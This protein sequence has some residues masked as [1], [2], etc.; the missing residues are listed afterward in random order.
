MWRQGGAF[1]HPTKDNRPRKRFMMEAAEAG[2]HQ[3]LEPVYLGGSSLSQ[4][5]WLFCPASVKRKLHA[6]DLEHDLHRG[7]ICDSD[8]QGL[9]IGR[10]PQQSR[11]YRSTSSSLSAIETRLAELVGASTVLQDRELAAR[12]KGC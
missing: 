1:A 9:L 7:A 4:L 8:E 11:G 10:D 2:E 12:W 6:L 5:A 3:G